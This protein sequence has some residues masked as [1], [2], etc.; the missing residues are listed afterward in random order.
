V[1]NIK[2][3][4][5]NLIAFL[6][7]A[8][9]KSFSGAATRLFLTQPAVTTKI[10]CLEKQFGVKLFMNTGKEMQL[11]EAA[12]GVLPIAEE[13]Y[14]NAKEI[15]Y[16]LSS[17]KDTKQG[18]L[19]IASSR[20]LSQAYLPPLI[21]IFSEHF[22]NIHIS[23]I[24][25]PSQELVEKLV[26]F[27]YDVAILPKIPLSDKFTAHT[28]SIEKVEFIVR[29]D[30]E[31]AQKPTV[32]IDDVLQAPILLPGEGSGARATALRIFERYGVTPNIALEA[33][34]LEMIKAFLLM[35]K[36]IALMFPPVV[37][38]ELQMGRLKILEVE[39]LNI[40]MDVQLIHLASH[41]LS[42]SAKQF[43]EITLS[44]FT[45]RPT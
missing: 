8:K 26:E 13:L 41:Q 4:L 40:F 45:S 12:K 28:V 32:T 43:V 30:H 21:G 11:T 10:K 9:E 31:L 6:F 17:F 44:T 24:E 20:S 35:G 29:S 42:P 18:S 25:G 15:E 3:N 38:D 2:I 36:G 33:E 19:R 7:V 34:N 39:G 5:D 23:I 1:E 16:T 14:K 27:K 22:P 37:R